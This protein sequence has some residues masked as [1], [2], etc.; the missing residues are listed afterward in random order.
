VLGARDSSNDLA[1][2]A[3][4]FYRLGFLLIL[5][6]VEKPRRRVCRLAL[7]VTLGASVCALVF[8]ERLF[9]ERRL[10]LRSAELAPAGDGSARAA[11]SGRTLL[12]IP[13]G[14]CVLED[15][16]PVAS[17]A[18]ALSGRSVTF[19]S[20]DGTDPLANGRRYELAFVP[21]R[22]AAAWTWPGL[23]LIGLTPATFLLA[24][25]TKLVVLGGPST[26]RLRVGLAL[27]TAIAFGGGVGKS[28]DAISFD[29]DTDSYL[30]HSAIRPLLYPAFVDLLDR[31]PGTSRDH[32]ER[33]D[34][35]RIEPE[36]RYLGVVHVQK[37][38]TVVSLALL[39]FV[40]SSSI[41]VW[42]LAAL[43][44]FG[45]LVDTEHLGGDSSI[46][47]NVTSVMSEGLNHALVFLL[48]A[49]LF[50]YL[51]APR[52]ARGIALGLVLALLLLNRPVNAALAGAIAVAWLGDRARVGWR[53]ASGRAL[54]IGL[55]AAIPLVLAC[56]WTWH[57]HGRFRLHAF[58]GPCVFSLALQ[59]ATPEDVDA[60]EDPELRALA[61]ACLVESAA[62]RVPDFRTSPKGDY[63]NVNLYEIGF[64]AVARTVR[65]PP[66]EDREFVADDRMLA[67][68]ERLVAR[69]P[70]AFAE[71]VLFHV[72]RLWDPTLH[73]LEA[74][75]ALGALVLYLKTRAFE[76]LYAL[77]FALLPVV[78]ML[79]TCVFNFPSER[80]H[81]QVYF[82]DY[83]AA[84]FVLSVAL[85]VLG[86][87]PGTG[88]L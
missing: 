55:A 52:P 45:T 43:L 65:V 73:V 11:F 25:Q 15:G 67:L 63:V 2:S 20:S 51:R 86:R 60:F 37:V 61:R 24:V 78:Y 9:P 29:K 34:R 42:Q 17:G 87:R 27:V 3:S 16:A 82:A 54:A 83:L 56:A 68:G 81:S 75:A 77:A 58:T 18:V 35:P 14:A 31:A 62:R 76:G 39:V 59:T 80:Y 12:R 71:V 74:L 33:S 21:D 32:V 57:A 7:A 22:V 5:G 66:G 47:W 85:A 70:G 46:W 69:H 26:K 19:R 49:A 48:L 53:R 84:P 79:P 41:N 50:E 40:L 64:P 44:V 36:N 28:W 1:E 13:A 10:D 23:A 8:P 88:K 6:R 30:A 38:V 72:G 4:R